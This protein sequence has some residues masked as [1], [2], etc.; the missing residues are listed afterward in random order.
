MGTESGTLE[1]RYDLCT[2][3]RA[4]QAACAIHNEK[5]L[6]PEAARIRVIQIGPGPLDV[7]VYC[8]Q[9]PDHPCVAACPSRVKALSFEHDSGVVKVDPVLCLRSRGANCRRCY[10][11][12]PAGAINYHPVTALPLF[13]HL[14]GGRPVCVEACGT[15]AL[16]Y[17]P[18]S[19]FD[20]RADVRRPEKLINDLALKIFGRADVT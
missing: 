20:S 10:Q 1:I 5:L 3:C 13:C 9:C 4:C 12:C 18:G 17:V 15:E 16:S 7:P 2:G 8:R 11:A 6:W 14:C 19:S